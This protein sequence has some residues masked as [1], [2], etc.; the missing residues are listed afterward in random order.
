MVTALQII[1]LITL[2]GFATWIAVDSYKLYKKQ[3][4]KTETE[5]AMYETITKYIKSRLD[6]S[7]VMTLDEY[8]NYVNGNLEKST[9]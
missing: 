1:I 3:V 7:I 8:N 2:L 4:S 6:V 5:Q 9:K